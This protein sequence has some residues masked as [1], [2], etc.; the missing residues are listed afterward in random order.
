MY[1]TSGVLKDSIHSTKRL[2]QVPRLFNEAGGQVGNLL[3]TDIR[4]DASE[5]GLE[6]VTER[7]TRPVTTLLSAAGG[8]REGTTEVTRDALTNPTE[9]AREAAGG[10]LTLSFG[11]RARATESTR[12]G[13]TDVRGATT[14]RASNRGGCVAS[15]GSDSVKCIREATTENIRC[16]RPHT[17]EG[18]TGNGGSPSRAGCHDI[19]RAASYVTEPRERAT[20]VPCLC[21]HASNS[22]NSV[23]SGCKQGGCRLLSCRLKYRL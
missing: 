9:P 1:T 8:S 14:K 15:A 11:G 7:T 20:G 3:D 12:Q 13:V 21:G 17:T 4:Q 10:A 23:I 2:L 18:I 22:R 5:C 6:R 19:V 16:H